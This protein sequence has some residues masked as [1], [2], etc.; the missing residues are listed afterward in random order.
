VGIDAEADDDTTEAPVVRRRGAWKGHFV[1]PPS[2]PAQSEAQVLIIS[3][4]DRY[5]HLATLLLLI[6]LLYTIYMT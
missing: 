2:A 3:F 6:C 4:G 1:L 5:S